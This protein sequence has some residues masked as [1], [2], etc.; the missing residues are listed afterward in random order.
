MPTPFWTAST[1]AW[2]ASLAPWP[3]R[4]CGIAG[5]FERTAAGTGQRGEDLGNGI[6]ERGAAG[7][8]AYVGQ[9]DGGKRNQHG[10]AAYARAHAHFGAL[11]A[12]IGDDNGC[13][14]LGPCWLLLGRGLRRI[15]GATTERLHELPDI[16]PCESL[17]ID[18]LGILHEYPFDGHWRTQQAWHINIHYD[19]SDPDGVAVLKPGGLP[20][21]KS[22]ISA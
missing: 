11:D 3:A 4:R 9:V 19:L 17:F 14:P 18:E 22:L 1:V 2:P 15:C 21:T 5:S 6:L 10:T 8:F 16:V 20:M 12:E 7:I 13:A